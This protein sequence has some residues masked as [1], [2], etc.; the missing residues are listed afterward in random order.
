MSDSTTMLAA[1][2]DAARTVGYLHTAAILH[3]AAVIAGEADGWAPYDRGDLYERFGR[4]ARSLPH[5]ERYSPIRELYLAAQA[6]LRAL[7]EAAR[8]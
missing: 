4:G 8:G 1:A 7:A 2:Q 5:F 3:A 6:H